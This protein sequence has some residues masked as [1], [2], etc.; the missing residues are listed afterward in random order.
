MAQ[1]SGARFLMVQTVVVAELWSALRTDVTR[2]ADSCFVSY[3]AIPELARHG[4]ELLPAIESIIKS[5]DF[6]SVRQ[7]EWLVE[8]NLL[9]L[10][11]VYFELADDRGWNSAQF[12]RSLQGS[13]LHEALIAVFQLWGPTRGRNRRRAIPQTLYEAWHSLMP[14]DPDWVGDREGLSRYVASGSLSLVGSPG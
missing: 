1:R 14:Q 8:R 12:L 9:H 3:L 5:Q 7:S 4:A 6:E 13:V 10:L 11:L 2:Y